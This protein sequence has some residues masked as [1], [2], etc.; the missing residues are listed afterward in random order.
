MRT[1]LGIHLVCLTNLCM[2]PTRFHL[3]VVSQTHVCC[4]T[5]TGRQ[6]I[7]IASIEHLLLLSFLCIGWHSRKSKGVPLYS[8]LKSKN[9]KHLHQIYMVYINYNHTWNNNT[10]YLSSLRSLPL[11]HYLHRNSNNHFAVILSIKTSIFYIL[12]HKRIIVKKYA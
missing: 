3:S 10:V 8:N 1:N 7:H 11:L 9:I 4:P 5:R 6:L 12:Y 2:V